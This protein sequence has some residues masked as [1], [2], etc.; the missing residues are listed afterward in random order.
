M[1]ERSL[2]D[3]TH[4]QAHTRVRVGLTAQHAYHEEV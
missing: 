4:A 1:S 3:C 2:P